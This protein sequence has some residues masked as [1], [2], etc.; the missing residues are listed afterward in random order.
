MI[1]NVKDLQAVG[2]RIKARREE[3]GFTQ[4]GLALAVRDKGPDKVNAMTI[5]RWERG[6]N[7]PSSRY[8]RALAEVLDVDPAYL[9]WGT[10]PVTADTTEPSALQYLESIASSLA[11]IDA[12]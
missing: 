7:H 10:T 12:K 9:L 5:S 2:R 3:L 8:Q 11:G 1:Q 6:K 4:D